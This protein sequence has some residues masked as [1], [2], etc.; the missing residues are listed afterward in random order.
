MLIIKKGGNL[1]RQLPQGGLAYGF[2]KLEVAEGEPYIGFNIHKVP[3]D[4]WKRT[5]AFLEWVYD[6]H[7]AEGLVKWYYNK[8]TGE[9]VD[10]APPQETSANGLSVSSTN[11]EET[12]RQR[13]E[14]GDGFMLMGTVH[15]HAGVSASQSGTDRED[16]LGEGVR[17]EGLHITVGRLG[18]QYDLHSRVVFRNCQYNVDLADW[19]ELPEEAGQIKS[20]LDELLALAPNMFP[21]LSSS[22]FH[23]VAQKMLTSKLLE[24]SGAEFP[25]QWK[26]NVVVRSVGFGGYGSRIHGRHVGGQWYNGT[27]TNNVFEPYNKAGWE[28]VNGLWVHYSEKKGH[29][30]SNGNGTPNSSNTGKETAK[31]IPPGEEYEW[32]DEE[33]ETPVSDESYQDVLEDWCQHLSNEDVK[34][35]SNACDLL[36]ELSDIA[37]NSVTDDLFQVITGKSSW[38]VVTEMND[39][40]KELTGF[41]DYLDTRDIV[42]EVE[43]ETQL[44]Q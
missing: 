6:E 13:G 3:W 38:E 37:G 42:K 5:L 2:E 27:W 35:M 10:W 7:K 23:E 9:W 17:K 12:N 40:L 44:P 29:K 15:S 8:E 41:W 22:T 28:R 33:T 26:E 25:G 1:Y 32:G 24:K 39:A 43:E 21:S 11:E 20:K 34:I 30:T 16:E 4:L 36:T 31:L 14:L 19:F 18:G